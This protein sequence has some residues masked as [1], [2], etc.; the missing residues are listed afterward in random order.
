MNR[1]SLVLDRLH[2]SVGKN[3][4]SSFIHF[5]QLGSPLVTNSPEE[6]KQELEF[7]RNK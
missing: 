7:A 2:N 1:A 3:V 5:P 4:Q 6:A